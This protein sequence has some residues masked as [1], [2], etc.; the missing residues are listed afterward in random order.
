MLRLRYDRMT[1]NVIEL[2]GTGPIVETV[3]CLRVLKKD[4]MLLLAVLMSELERVA[5]T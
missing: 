5:E 2:C 4:R 1:S 3:V